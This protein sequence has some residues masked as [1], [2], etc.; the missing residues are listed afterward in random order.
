MGMVQ[1]IR[2]LGPHD[3]FLKDLRITSVKFIPYKSR[4]LRIV[5]FMEI[6]RRPKSPPSYLSV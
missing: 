4:I 2:T 3:K 1:S 6:R 5:L